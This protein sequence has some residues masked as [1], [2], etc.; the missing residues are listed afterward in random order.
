M[1]RIAMVA[2]TLCLAVCGSGVL[3]APPTKEEAANTLR[4]LPWQRGPGTGAVGN[5]GT[6]AIPNNA[7][8][9]SEADGSKF[10]EATGNL[11]SP[12]TSIIAGEDWWAAFEFSP[13]GYV[14]DDDKID[15]DALL[16]SIK[17]S[18][19]AAN[20]ERRKRGMS[21]LHTLGWYVPPHYDS[22]TKHLEWALKLSTSDDPR[23]VIN[24]TVR[25]LGRSG[26]ESV[27]LV[28]SPEALDAN[29]A[30]LKRML[31]TYSF[32]PG[33]QYSEFKPGDHVA[34]FGL[35]ALV[36]GGAVALATKTG[37]W[38]VLLAS[39]AAFWKVIAVAGAAVLA[40][41]GKFFKRKQV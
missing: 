19:E 14:K 3:A 11:P 24:Y 31:S 40:A 2:L 12:G 29:V 4:S 22:A 28:S 9:L 17:D 16:K 25:L 10:L 34:E 21:E 30:S 39:L 38:K 32:N 37:F 33:E 15:P 27:V 41:I 1:A 7:A 35:A 36:A 8:F 23:P 20:D 18:D 5:K 6:F 13:V 26:V